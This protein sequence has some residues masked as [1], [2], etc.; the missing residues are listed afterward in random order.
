MNLF[1]YPRNM[2][3]KKKKNYKIHSI[4]LYYKKKSDMIK[5]YNEYI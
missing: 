2:I 3:K 1:D 4:C 5:L